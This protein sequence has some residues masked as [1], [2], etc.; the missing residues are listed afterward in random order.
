MTTINL[1]VAVDEARGLGKN[2]ALLCHLPE[3]LKHFKRLTMGRPIVMGRKT[4]ESIGRLL[5]GRLNIIIS[6]HA[7]PILGAIVC[8]DMQDVL[9][10]MAAEPEIMIIGGS[11]IFQ[12]FMP[13]ANHVY[14]TLIHHRFDADVFFPWMNEN[15]WVCQTKSFHKK[16]EKN[17]YDLT[18]YDYQR[19]VIEKP[20][21]KGAEMSRIRITP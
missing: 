3:D 18:F 1:V 8:R 2:N 9:Y 19:K 7:D 6:R 16:D 12:M 10:R 11:Q 17:F 21:D 15:D 13:L 14:M 5:P 4:Y 20:V